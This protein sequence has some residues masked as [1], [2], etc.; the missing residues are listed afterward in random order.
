MEE[1]AVS[2]HGKIEPFKEKLKRLKTEFSFRSFLMI[3]FGFA[4]LT[5]NLVLFILSIMRAGQTRSVIEIFKFFFFGVIGIVASSVLIFLL[6]IELSLPP[7]ESKIR[8]SKRKINSE[9][10]QNQFQIKEK[11]KKIY[12]NYFV[13]FCF[14]CCWNWNYICLYKQRSKICK[15]SNSYCHSC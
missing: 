5:T 1:K 12:I 10:E 14:I 7:Q 9:F 8:Y 6:S 4:L 15:L 2:I 3:L 13:Y 11:K